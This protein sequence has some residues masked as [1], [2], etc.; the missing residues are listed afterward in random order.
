MIHQAYLSALGI[1]QYFPKWQLPQAQESILDERYFF[2]LEDDFSRLVDD[3][4]LPD[5]KDHPGV[6]SDVNAVQARQLLNN[7]IDSKPLIKTDQIVKSLQVESRQINKDNILAPFSLSIWRPVEGMLVIDSRAVKKPLPVELLLT[8][9]LKPFKASKLTLLEEV[10]RWPMVETR[11]TS[12][13]FHTAQQELLTWLAVEND[14][15]PIKELWLMGSSAQVC[16]FEEGAQLSPFTQKYIDGVDL[17]AYLTPSLSE[18][19][20]DPTVKPQLYTFLLDSIDV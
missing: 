15:R 20:L 17:Y 18:V 4:P 5:D 14:L 13:S 8:N 1:E 3:V 2:E 19:L 12:S 10:L 6:L 11:Y 7:L 9:I 16:F